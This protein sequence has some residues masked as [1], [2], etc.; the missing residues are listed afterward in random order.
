MILEQVDAQFL[1][2]DTALKAEKIS[3]LNKIILKQADSQ[4]KTES[5]VKLKD[6]ALKDSQKA[7]NGLSDMFKKESSKKVI[8][9]NTSVILG[10]ISIILSCIIILGMN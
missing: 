5:I 1:R 2:K 7:F 8:W 4:S 9:R 3:S 6:S 10:S